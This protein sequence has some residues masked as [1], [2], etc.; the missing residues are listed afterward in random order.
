MQIKKKENKIKIDIKLE[1]NEEIIMQNCLGIYIENNLIKYAKISKDKN[2]FKVE[3]Y[4]LKFF[5]NIN[6]A[7][8]KL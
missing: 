3:A 6:D 8:K 1:K 7:I 2:N 5:E 4:G